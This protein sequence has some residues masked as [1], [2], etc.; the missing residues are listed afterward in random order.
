MAIKGEIDAYQRV[1]DGNHY[2]L[3]KLDNFWLMAGESLSEY[4]AKIDVV[5]YR[6]TVPEGLERKVEIQEAEQV[7]KRLDGIHT[8]CEVYTK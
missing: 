5:D 4:L 1:F 2:Q 3:R 8:F 6:I 7:I